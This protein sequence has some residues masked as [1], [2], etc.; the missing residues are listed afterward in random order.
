MLFLSH[1][2]ACQA[3]ITCY[4]WNLQTDDVCQ[5]NSG[6]KS[7]CALASVFQIILISPFNWGFLFFHSEKSRGHVAYSQTAAVQDF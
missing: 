4:F 2:N 1:F 5:D 3:F 7:A 6:V